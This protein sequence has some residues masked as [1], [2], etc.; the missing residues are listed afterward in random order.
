MNSEHANLPAA[1]WRLVLLQAAMNGSHF[2]VMPLLA[3]Y[4]SEHLS[5]SAS[6]IGLV[7][8]I[9][10]IAARVTPMVFGPLADR[11]GLWPSVIL[12]LWLRGA[13]FFGLYFADTEGLAL[14]TAAILGL[15]TSIYEAGA[16]G[17]IGNQKEACRERL[18]IE[19]A[20]ALNLGCILGPLLGAGLAVYDLALPLL[21]SGAIFWI[22]CGV[23]L[24]ERAPE[25]RAHQRQPIASSLS[26]VWQDRAFILLCLALLPWWALFAQLFAAF[27]LEASARGGAASWAS[28]VLVVN[29]SIGL[30]FLFAIPVIV[31]RV[32]ANR[33]IAL[34]ALIG[35]L[36]VAGLAVAKGLPGLLV[37]VAVFTCAEVAILAASEILVGRHAA[38]QSTATFFAMFN[39]SWGLCGALGGAIGPWISTLSSPAL[40]WCGLGASALLTVAGLRV[41]DVVSKS[42]LVST[43]SFSRGSDT[44]T[45]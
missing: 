25:L 18:I 44:L 11:Y 43:A 17:V 40:A 7:L 23:T 9:Y 38:G 41:Y 2:M 29:G 45:R 8:A 27:P 26:A 15:G 20:R 10:F 30:L 4:C 5:L 22:M 19:N 33:T 36:A 35:G 37:L 39:V 13:G 1:L 28:S 21:V 14:S 16:Y 32:G 42:Q 24:C 3:V 6:S 34:G 31:S 12:G